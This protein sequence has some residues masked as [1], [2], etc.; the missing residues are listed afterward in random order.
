[1][2]ELSLDQK[3]ISDAGL[4]DKSCVLNLPTGSGKTWLA[5]KAIHITLARKLKAVYLSPLRAIAKELSV[6]WREEFQG[7]SVGVY[8]GEVG[9]DEDENPDP[10]DADVLIAT[11]EKFDLYLRNFSDQLGWLSKI[12]L[13]VV[14]ELH[15]LDGGRRGST[16]EGLISR[17]KQINPYARIMGLSATLGNVPELAKWIGGESYIST[18]RSIPLDWSI[19][20]YSKNTPKVNVVAEEILET[21]SNDGQVIVF[22]QSRPRAESMASKLAELGINAVALHAGLSKTVRDFAAKSF[23]D[24]QIDALVSTAVIA[25]GINFPARKVILHDLQR[26]GNGGWEDLSTNEV[27]QL[28]GRAGRKGL[29]TTGEVVLVAPVWNQVSARRYIKGVFEPIQSQLAYPLGFSEQLM[30]VFGSRM[31]LKREQAHRVMGSTLFGQETGST[32][33]LNRKV[34]AAI[35]D[36]AKAGMLEINEEG[37]IRATR[38]GRIATR[39]QLTAQTVLCWKKFE[40]TIGNATLFDVLLAV[41]ASSDFNSKL[42]ADHKGLDKLQEAVSREAMELR[43][44]SDAK[45]HAV[46]GTSGKHLV[47]AVLTALT[48]RNWTRCGDMVEATAAFGVMEHEGE[49]AR[50]E[51]VRLLQ[52][53]SAM[54]QT[55]AKPQSDDITGEAVLAEKIRALSAMVCAGL[56]DESAT[57]ALIDGI[58]PVLARKLVKAKINDIEDLAQADPKRIAEIDGISLK[59]ATK[60]VNL[61]EEFTRG[62]GAYRYREVCLKSEGSGTVA[63]VFSGLDYYRWLRAKD[64]KVI[65]TGNT[66]CVVGGS[67]SHV[68]EKTDGAYGCDCADSQKGNLCKH[69]I[70]VMHEEG[71]DGIPRFFSG[72]PPGASG[73]DLNGLWNSAASNCLR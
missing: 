68:V 49:E 32:V 6:S 10:K 19:S 71:I 53:F 51:A 42:R 61:A 17:F 25:M 47:G 20:P 46:L 22:V 13:L 37:Y 30:V 14:D 50:K 55:K 48:L 11:P 59:R 40:D 56:D 28:G 38:L 54:V 63:S 33:V 41:C 64:L 72:F 45:R 69:R 29:D 18:Q 44:L 36:M 26:W 8:T 23:C 4:L 27:W 58:G 16:L 24:G 31:A 12:D 35:D 70:A 62:S 73:F 67:E 34:D 65:A 3:N 39:F 15:T 43:L 57:L 1:M 7:Y 21:I 5:R 2:E 66:W 9:L 60:W 52:A